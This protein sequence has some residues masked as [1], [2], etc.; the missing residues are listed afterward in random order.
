MK[1]LFK[2]FE[3]LFGRINLYHTDIY[4]DEINL[5]DRVPVIRIFK[6]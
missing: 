1:D 4:D 3:I 6:N 2:D 5:I